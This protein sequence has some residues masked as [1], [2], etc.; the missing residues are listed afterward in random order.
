[1]GFGGVC[2]VE[3]VLLISVGLVAW[4]SCCCEFC[5]CLGWKKGCN[6]MILRFCSS[7]GAGKSLFDE[8][9]GSEYPIL[10]FDKGQL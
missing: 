2:V 7:S 6:S 9:L 8:G 3:V 5:G 4:R 10:E 1:V